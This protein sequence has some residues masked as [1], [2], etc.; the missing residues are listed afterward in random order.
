MKLLDIW[1]ELLSKRTWV[2][3]DEIGGW[4]NKE[5]KKYLFP[6]GGPVPKADILPM[7]I[8]NILLVSILL[9][10]FFIALNR[11]P[12]VVNIVLGVLML[13]LMFLPALLARIYFKDKE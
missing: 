7:A 13:I 4:W 1:K 10:I 2:R 3:V 5:K 9:I 6:G 8:T 12:F 11:F